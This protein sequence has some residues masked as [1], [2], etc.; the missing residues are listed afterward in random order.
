MKSL[1][2]V[3]LYESLM[4][5]DQ[6]SELFLRLEILKDNINFLEYTEEKSSNCK[7]FQLFQFRIKFQNITA[8]FT[9]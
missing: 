1:I 3:D 4:Y 6:I 5:L 7:S 8:T 2:R 9:F